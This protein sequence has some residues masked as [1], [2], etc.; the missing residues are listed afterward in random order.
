MHTL[1]ERAAA[2]PRHPDSTWPPAAPTRPEAPVKGALQAGQPASQDAGQGAT[3][4]W[5]LGGRPLPAL[6]ACAAR[7]DS[8][9]WGRAR[10][11]AGAGGGSFRA[12]SGAF[13][14]LPASVRTCPAPSDPDT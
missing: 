10:A 3:G 7:L 13:C 8:T 9:V 11:L 14:L 5:P 1:R 2:S 6:R 4:D 12:E